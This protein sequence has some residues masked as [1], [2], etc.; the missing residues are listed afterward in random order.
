MTPKTYY[1]N[2]VPYKKFIVTKYPNDKYL[3]IGFLRI[4][5]V[6]RQFMHDKVTSKRFSEIICRIPMPKKCNDNCTLYA[7]EKTINKYSSM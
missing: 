2:T 7:H 3:I 1:L 5:N 6:W 4:N